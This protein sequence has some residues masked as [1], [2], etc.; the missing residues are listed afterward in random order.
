M[1][2]KNNSAPTPTKKTKRTEEEKQRRSK[3]LF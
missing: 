2:G 1:G 3:N